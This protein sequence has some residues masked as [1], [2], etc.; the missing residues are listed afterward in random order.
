MPTK[1][2]YMPAPH[3]L[4]RL[5]HILDSVR[6]ILEKTRGATIATLTDDLDTRSAI[7]YHFVIIGEAANHLTPALT[8]AYPQIRW[9]QI[10]GLRNIMAHEYFGVDYKAAWGIISME[11][12]VLA[13]TVEQMIADYPKED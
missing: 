13:N 2:F 10:V 7:F 12:P 5:E 9:R 1:S 6:Y 11:L 3:E 4:A 8:S